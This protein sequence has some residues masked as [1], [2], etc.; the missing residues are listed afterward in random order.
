MGRWH[1]HYARRAGSR[2]CAV[3]DPSLEAAGAIA[4][5]APVF[6]DMAAMLR[7]ARPRAV[8]L[9]TPAQSHVALASLAI[10]AGAHVLVEKPLAPSAAE[11]AALLQRAGARGVH[12]CPV[13]QFAFQ[14]G[15]ARAAAA[16]PSL[17]QPL[18][19][20]F[21]VC[22]AGAESG[23]RGTPD[24]IVADVLPHP[25]SVLQALWPRRELRPED[26][27]ARRPGP[28]ELHLD[29]VCGPLAV[30]AWISM[31]ARPTRCELEIA[32]TLGS[33]HVNFFHGYAV[34]RRGQPSRADKATQPF[35]ASAGT[36]AAAAVNLAGRALRSE[37]AYPGLAELV[38][39]FHAAARGERDTP[40]PA[41]HALAVARVR[42]HLLPP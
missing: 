32:C 14:R 41:S 8:H 29:G 36:F 7:E 28:G 30:T 21:V 34:V 2:V 4:R 26:W 33:I 19:A 24:E 40:I 35:R 23:A 31:N 22:S 13:H 6:D 11:T 5:G 37:L 9:C 20:A 1:S 38:A 16:L 3:V 25:L 27:S 10:E 17:G 39:A 42:D 18:R 15:I 12:A